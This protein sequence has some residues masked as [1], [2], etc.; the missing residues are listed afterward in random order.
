MV[1]ELPVPLCLVN[2][3]PMT[4]RL[5]AFFAKL[6]CTGPFISSCRLQSNGWGYWQAEWALQHPSFWRDVNSSRKRVEFL[7]I[8]CDIW[9]DD[10]LAGPC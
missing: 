7:C 9:Y 4:V 1:M 3:N 5:K 8:L 10:L 2:W 6:T